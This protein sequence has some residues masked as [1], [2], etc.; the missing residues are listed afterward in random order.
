MKS[1]KT[2]PQIRMVQFILP[3]KRDIVLKILLGLLIMTFSVLRAFAMGRGASAVLMRSGTEIIVTFLAIAVGSIM[4]KAVL[5]YANEIFSKKLA[6]RVKAGIR[7]KL[8]EKLFRL[9]PKYQTNKRSGKVQ[10]LITDGVE[11]LESYLVYY[12]PQI[13]IALFTVVTLV[14]YICRIDLAV[15]LII[16]GM[17][18]VAVIG[19]HMSRTLFQSSTTEYWKAYAVLN[20]QYIDTMQGMD[21]LKAFNSNRAKGRELAENCWDFHRKQLRTTANSL[22]DSAFVV[23]CMGIGTSFCVGL[24]AY[25]AAMGEVNIVSLLSVLFLIPE[26]FKPITELNAFWHSSYLGFSVADQLFEILD[27]PIVIME[28]TDAKTTGLESGLPTISIDDVSFRYRRGRENVLED[29]DIDILPG[30]QIA[31]VGKSGCG[32]STIVNLLLRF[33]D[34]DSGKILYNGTDIRDY[35]LDYLRQKIAV[36]FQDTYLFYG[37]IKENIAMSKPEADMK[38]VIEAAKAANIHDFIVS[39]PFGY[40]TIVGERGA[41]LSG[42]ERQRIA[43]A[44]AVLKDAPFLI[45]D[46][47][48][49]SVDAE[50]EKSIQQALERLMQDKT[51]L[52][53][54]HRLSTIRNADKIYVLD[55]GKICESGIHEELLSECSIYAKLISAQ[56]MS[57]EVLK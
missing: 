50:N 12:I 8:L 53:I 28:K 11:A 23:L 21:T 44:R 34:L 48:T 1:K 40:D 25:H 4:L 10:S 13:F 39:L 56:N 16:L 14:V 26:S 31:V 49:A 6:C 19:P 2:N 37:T 45:L 47:A 55:D 30:Q 7:Q 36:V 5:I 22:I 33:Y 20:S 9:G 41:N 32:K 15:G 38:K 35:S 18:I 24:A 54:A 29:V 17:V 42:G 3:F 51:S 57:M 46:E 52:V 43:I 27:E